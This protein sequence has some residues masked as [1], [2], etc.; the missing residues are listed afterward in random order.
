MSTSVGLVVGALAAAWG[1]VVALLDQP[2]A[3]NKRLTDRLCTTLL[4][5]CAAAVAGGGLA[6]ITGLW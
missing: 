5:A 2:T 6:K 1:V 4:V 3:S